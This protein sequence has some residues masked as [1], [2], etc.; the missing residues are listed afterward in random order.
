MKIRRDRNRQCKRELSRRTV[1][2][3]L[4]V[5]MALP[6]LESLPAFADKPGPKQ[7]GAEAPL[8]LGVLF[9]G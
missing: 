7:P 8:R 6:W 3:G 2:R 1:L 5:S 4:G 9:A